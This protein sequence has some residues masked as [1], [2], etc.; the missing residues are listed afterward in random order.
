MR[1]TRLT[2]LSLM[3][4]CLLVACGGGGEEGPD[5]AID[6]KPIDAAIDAPAGLTGLGKKCT[7][8]M[9]GADCPANAPACV[10]FQ[11][12]GSS[13]CSPLCVTNGTAKGAMNN[14]FTMIMPAPNNM[15]CQS[16]YNGTVGAGVCAGILPNFMPMDNPTVVGKDYTNINMTCA[17]V[18]GN[19]MMCPAGTVSNTSLGACICVPS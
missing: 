5:A 17:I 3:L 1:I 4:G 19:G 13:Y 16:A 8:A 10:G 15:I 12:I 6:A 18:C 14:Q 11:G 2:L 9:M 7:P